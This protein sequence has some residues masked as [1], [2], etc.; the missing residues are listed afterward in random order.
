MGLAL[1]PGMDLVLGWMY[2]FADINVKWL[3]SS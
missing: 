3:F 1:W 2:V